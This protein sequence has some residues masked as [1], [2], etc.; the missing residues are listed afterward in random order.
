R[1]FLRFQEELARSDN[2]KAVV[3]GLRRSPDDHCVLMNYFL[4]SLGIALL[5]GDI[6]AKKFEKRIDELLS[7][8]RF[9]V[10]IDLVSLSMLRVPSYQIEKLRGRF[11]TLQASPPCTSKSVVWA[12]RFRVVHP[13]VSPRLR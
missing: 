3:G 13:E 10:R 4:V 7:E 8:L 6:P 11:T 9:F 2:P 5:V 1:R 12:N